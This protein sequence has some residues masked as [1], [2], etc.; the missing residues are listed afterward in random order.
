[1]QGV[2]ISVW[3]VYLHSLEWQAF[4]REIFVITETELRW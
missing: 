3:R 1:M 2:E 4:K